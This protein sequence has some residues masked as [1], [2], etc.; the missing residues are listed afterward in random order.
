MSVSVSPLAVEQSTS[1]FQIKL[2]LLASLPAGWK[3]SVSSSVLPQKAVPGDS[4]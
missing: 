3:L 4:H 2:K 1:D